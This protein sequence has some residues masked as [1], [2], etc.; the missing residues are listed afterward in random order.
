MTQQIKHHTFQLPE[1]DIKVSKI[2]NLLGYSNI[3]CPGPFRSM[4]SEILDSSEKY[5]SIEGGY[6]VC[7]GEFTGTPPHSLTINDVCF[8]PGKII[9]GQLRK[10]ETFV[11]FVCTA[12]KGMVERSKMLSANNDPLAAYIC[13]I[14][15]SVVV[16]T[17]MDKLQELIKQEMERENLGITNRYSPGYCGWSTTEQRQLFSLFP[18]GF[19]NVS[20][21][22][23]MMMDPVK[24]VSGIIGAGRNVKYN[25]YICKLCDRDNCIY[26]NAR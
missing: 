24:S 25:P 20:L 12:G 18:K 26:K 22:N 3:D 9:M 13:N 6:I 19:C 15:G 23:S 14:I 5:C 17:A 4:I 10:S 7:H 2:E 11:F 8:N 16:E 1:L 21:T